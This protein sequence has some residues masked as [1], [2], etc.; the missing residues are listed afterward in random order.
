MML[1]MLKD[2]MN[3][4]DFIDADL[5]SKTYKNQNHTWYDG[6]PKDNGY[7][8]MGWQCPRCK[9][10]NSPMLMQCYCNEHQ[11]YNPHYPIKPYCGTGNM[12]GGLSGGSQL[13]INF[14]TN[15]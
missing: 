11:P 7:I 4:G 6:Y 15:V 8:S 9:R 14:D 12:S 13:E 5:N 10:I 1:I 3:I 2:N